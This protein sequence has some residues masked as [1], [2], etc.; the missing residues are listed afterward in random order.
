[1]RNDAYAQPDA[2]PL[3]SRMHKPDPKLGPDQQDKRSLMLLEPHDFDQWLAGTVEDAQSLVKLTPVETFAA[4][5]AE[6][7]PKVLELE[8]T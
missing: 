1:M 3:M 4:G 2:H 6:A 7:P 5:P 8:P